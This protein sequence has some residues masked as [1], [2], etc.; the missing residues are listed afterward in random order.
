MINTV[1][2]ASL[3]KRFLSD[4]TAVVALTAI[5]GTMVGMILIAGFYG[6]YLS[7]D[8]LRTSARSGRIDGGAGLCS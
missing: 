1:A 5:S 6:L 3:L 2:S 7:S 8:A 4:V